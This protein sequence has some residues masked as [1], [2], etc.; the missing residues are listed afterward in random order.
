MIICLLD[1]LEQFQFDLK[2]KN[3]KMD[4][5]QKANFF[6][7]FGIA[8]I[9]L[10]A[11]ISSF[12]NPSSWIGFV[13]GFIQNIIPGMVFLK[14]YSIFQIGLSFWLFSGKKTFYAAILSALT[15][16]GIIVFNIGAF[17]IIFRDVAI[18]FSCIALAFM[19][20]EK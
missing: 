20:K 11:A 10:Y 1:I 7:R 18:F 2:Q 8:L 13:P 14:I 12:L 6:L 19:S 17:D 9:F 16:L 5:I 4:N 15:V 3:L